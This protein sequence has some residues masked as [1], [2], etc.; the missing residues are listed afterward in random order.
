MSEDNW[1]TLEAPKLKKY[2]NPR[3]IR[4]PPRVQKKR[5]ALERFMGSKIKPII[6]E[7]HRDRQKL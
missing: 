2:T 7:N 1:A 5:T 3:N 4:A 6:E